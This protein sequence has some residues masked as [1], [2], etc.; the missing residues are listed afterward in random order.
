MQE[1]F[2]VFLS[3]V[4]AL[5][6][7]EAILYRRI[8]TSLRKKNGEQQRILGQYELVIQRQAKSIEFL[9]SEVEGKQ[10][11]IEALKGENK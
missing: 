7:L 11:Y 9:I 5:A 3:F 2:I 8:I 10:N 1:L 6:L 4:A